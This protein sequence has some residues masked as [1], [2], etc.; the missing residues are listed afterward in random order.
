MRPGTS[1]F[2][3]ANQLQRQLTVVTYAPHMADPNFSL[4]RRCS[5]AIIP[6]ELAAENGLFQPIL[7]LAQKNPKWTPQPG[8]TRAGAKQPTL[9]PSNQNSLKALCNYVSQDPV[10]SWLHGVATWRPDAKSSK[11]GRLGRQTRVGFRG[12]LVEPG[13]DSRDLISPLVP[14]IGVWLAVTLAA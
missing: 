10:A 14:C 9:S 1:D 8:R 7:I 6:R 2:A 3:G 13:L 4:G 12:D 11:I 5:P